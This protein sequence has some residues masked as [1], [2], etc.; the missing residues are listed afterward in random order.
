MES[1]KSEHALLRISIVGGLVWASFA[2]FSLFLGVY[3]ISQGLSY[4]SIGLLMTTTSILSSF[5]QL[6]F[7]SLADKYQNTRLI[8][9]LTL[10]ARS[11]ACLILV[12]S[13]DLASIL[14]WY[15]V[16]GVFLSG[17]LPIA[18]SMVAKLSEDE[19]LGF[20]MGK[21]RLSGS[22]GWAFSCILTGLFAR[23]EMW[24]IFPITLILSF[25]SFLTSLVIPEV[26]GIAVSHREIGRRETRKPA[27][28]IVFFILSIFLSS[29][30]MSAASSFL[31]IFLFQ[32]GSD[33]FFIGIIIA[34]GAFLEVPAMYLGGILSDKIGEIL[35]LMAG[36][37]G[38]G[39]IYWLYG[40]VKNI[41]TYIIIQGFR[42]I[43]YAFFMVSGMSLSSNVGDVGKKG[44][45]AGLYNLSLQFGMALG[46]FLGGLVSD[47]FGLLAM[48]VTVSILSELSSALLIPFAF[49]AKKKNR[50]KV[51]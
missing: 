45:Y 13:R 27:K 22:L 12:F 30:S 21:Y 14:L 36:E 31:N 43:L 5:L 16:S 20:S 44:F 8:I 50:L 28:L 4:A 47:A 23:Y 42:G 37:M 51:S 6:A 15:I 40:T 9:S 19:R 7:G 17:F 39:V 34:I 2:P 26:E 10:L 11:I 35:V 29:L 41:Y 25:S 46:P 48:F 3:L 1:G 32:L 49:S 18:Q 24:N 38:L 33:P